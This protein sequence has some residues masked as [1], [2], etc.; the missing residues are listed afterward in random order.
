MSAGRRYSLQL[1]KGAAMKIDW[2]NTTEGDS[3]WEHAGNMFALWT[4]I[5]KYI[6]VFFP[7]YFWWE[8]NTCVFPMEE[9]IESD[10][11]QFLITAQTQSRPSLYF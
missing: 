4:D 2:N 8:F 9:V 3:C 10:C 7:N 6:Q 5:H 11:L 1:E